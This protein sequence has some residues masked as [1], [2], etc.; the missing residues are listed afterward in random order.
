MKPA[1]YLSVSA[2]LLV[3]GL[4]MARRDQLSAPPPTGNQGVGRPAL[5]HR[6]TEVPR[7]FLY[8]MQTGP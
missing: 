2:F 4:V 6:D 1:T 7:F 5:P 8:R 3:L